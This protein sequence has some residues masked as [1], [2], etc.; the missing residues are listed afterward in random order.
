MPVDNLRFMEVVEANP[1]IT[2]ADVEQ[3]LWASGEIPPATRSMFN[4]AEKELTDVLFKQ[5]D[6]GSVRY[7][8]M[9]FAI[10]NNTPKTKRKHVAT[11]KY[12][13]QS[14]SGDDIESRAATG[15]QRVVDS[16]WVCSQ[17]AS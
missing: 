13:R 9:L 11:K 16:M 14:K 8:T 6:G 4:R 15:Y 3:K 1:G 7:F 12:E 5:D 17:V 2:R 10:Q